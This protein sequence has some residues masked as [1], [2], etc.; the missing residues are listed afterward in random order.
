MMPTARRTIYY[1]ATI[2][3]G[4]VQSIRRHDTNNLVP[5]AVAYLDRIVRKDHYQGPLELEFPGVDLILPWAD[6]LRSGPDAVLSLTASNGAPI[7]YSALV[8]GIGTSGPHLL[9]AMQ[10]LSIQQT[11]GEAWDGMPATGITRRPLLTTTIF[12]AAADALGADLEPM[13]HVC[14]ELETLVAAAF[15]SRL[16]VTANPT[17]KDYF[18]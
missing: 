2:M 13:L 7:T 6:W 15:F 17:D 14:A 8:S 1:D 18:S 4:T 11:G 3:G 5:E 16:R 10:T 12:T 9:D